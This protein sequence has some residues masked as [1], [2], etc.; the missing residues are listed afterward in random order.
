MTVRAIYENGVFR[1]REK[2]N[3]PD[4]A[5]VVFEPRVIRIDKAPSK[6]MAKIYEI[7]ARRHDAGE[8]DF[9]ERHNEHQP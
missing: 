4:Q 2:V 6:A 8:I 9:A 7:M 1:P 5:E 3:L